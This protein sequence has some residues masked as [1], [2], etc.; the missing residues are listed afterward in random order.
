MTWTPPEDRESVDILHQEIERL[1]RIY[2]EPIV[3]CYLEGMTLEMAA[4]H[5]RCPIGTLGVRLMRARERLKSRLSRR[6][7]T[8]PAALLIAGLS[9]R[10]TT[11]ALPESLIRST[12][13]IGHPVRI[14][15]DDHARRHRTGPGRA[16]EDG[17]DPGG[18]RM[19]GGP[20][21]SGRRRIFGTHAG[22]SRRVG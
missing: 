8:A 17:L 2:R 22:T 16:Q 11:S 14:E 3:V 19:L 12:V 13:R 5:L 21:D 1:P 6:G 9:G 15:R 20:G 4:R 18:T 10:S 7:I